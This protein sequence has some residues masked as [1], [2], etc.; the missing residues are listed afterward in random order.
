MKKRLES[1]QKGFT[2][3]EMLLVIAI[4]AILAGIVIVA[5][6][7]GRQLAQARNAQR[8]S[9]LR[10]IHSA[11]N[12][13]YID[14]REWP[15]DLDADTSLTEICDTGSATEGHGINCT[16]LVDLSILVPTYI[17][18][19]PS[20]PQG[21]IASIPFINTANAQTTN[22]TG[23][24]ITIKESSQTPAV[25]AVKSD[26]YALDMVGIGVINATELCGDLLLD[27]RD[28][29]TYKTVQI[30]T[31]CWMQQNLNVGDMLCSNN[32][33]G[34]NCPTYQGTSSENID[35]YCY[36]NLES[37][38][39]E[40]GG[41]YQWNQLMTGSN[42]PGV[43]GICPTGWHV[44]TDNEWKNLEI[45]LGMTSSDADLA[46]GVPRNS[47]N[48]GS[49]L[50]NLTSDGNNSSGFTALLPGLKYV[51][52]FDEIGNRTAFWTSDGSSFD[53]AWTRRLDSLE[54]DVRRYTIS[55]AMSHSVR[56]LL[57]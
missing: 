40:Y 3:L 37:N 1:Y 36:N 13:F 9:D 51:N 7:P 52:A 53:S 48:V 8:A 11:V 47:G 15:A 12:Q 31:Q 14:N 55:K 25:V 54:S 26:E 28:F 39:D 6:N 29:Q 41:L 43:Q 32:E 2:L 18:A 49:Q 44:P 45:Y 57:N 19:I 38:C 21:S 5:I 42:E 22:G 34:T 30:G 33:G 46:G 4:I 16:D 27:T 20:D 24:M 50:S 56:C 17:P 23:Y 10:A 35:K